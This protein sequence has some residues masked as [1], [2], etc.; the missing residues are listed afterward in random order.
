MSI[1][2]YVGIMGSGK[3]YEVV[4]GVVFNSLKAGRRVVSNIAGLNFDAMKA[5]MLADGVPETCIGQL[6]QIDHAKVMEPEFWRTDDDEELGI[7][8]FIQPGDV[9]ALDEIWRFWEGFSTKDSEG[10]KRPARVM[11]FFRMHRQFPH[12]ETGVTCDVALI[13]QDIMDLARQM[14]SVVEETYRMEKLTVVG[15]S[16][17]YRVDIFKGWKIRTKPLR[18][19]QRSYDPE[20]F[21]FYKS[22]SQQ[23][24]GQAE[25]REE[26]ID[27]RG[28]ILHGALFK[29]VLPIGLVVFGFSV[30]M[31]WGFLH[32]EKKE[33][34]SEVAKKTDTVEKAKQEAALKKASVDQ[35][36]RWRVV[37]RYVT[38][39]G[40][41]FILS[42]GVRSRFILNPPK[43]K[44]MSHS[45]EVALPNDEIA[46]SW[47]SRRSESLT[48]RF[49]K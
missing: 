49:P 26:N 11:N 32:P 35:S 19:I 33:P 14:R 2:A 30:W 16:D 42:D 7:D 23:K 8:A 21:C 47:S 44:I 1:K 31:V 25:A 39:S 18:Q 45:S 22:H 29:I 24:E 5:R 37:G 10:K 46:V 27:K 43:Y 15:M 4:T 41:T 6:V 40:I 48:D 17:R 36:D 20:L 9:V 34:S 12:P 13:C 28:N 38:E 3:T